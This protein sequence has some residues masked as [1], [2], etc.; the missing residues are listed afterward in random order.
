M[1]KFIT[2]LVKFQGKSSLS[3][4]YDEHSSKEWISFLTDVVLQ[5]VPILF[6]LGISENLPFQCSAY[7]HLDE[8]LSE[9]ICLICNLKG[10]QMGHV[11]E[12]VCIWLT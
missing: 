6:F 2:Q 7:G 12:F 10:L 9:Y 8:V 3:L 4:L 11:S 1:I 5:T